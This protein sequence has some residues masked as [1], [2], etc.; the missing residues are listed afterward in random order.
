MLR[1]RSIKVPSPASSAGIRR[2]DL[3]VSCDGH[4][5]E[6]WIDFYF[7][8]SGLKIQLLFRRAGIQRSTV[9][10]RSPGNDW[11]I[12]FQGQE[13]RRCRRKCVFCFVDQL[14]EGVRPSL[15]VKDDDVRYSFISG[16]YTTL[17]EGDAEFAL[18]R[19]L[20]PIHISVHA[21]DPS[22]R[23][24]LLGTGREEP[25]MESLMKLSA[26]GIQMETQ[27][28]V[29]PGYNDGAVL[30]STMKDLFSINGVSSVG[31]VP[32]GLTAFRKGLTELRR[33][34]RDESACVIDLCGH[35][36]KT[37]AVNGRG[38]W[39]FPS[40]EFFIIAD[41]GIPGPGYYE[42]CTLRENGIGMLAELRELKGRK[43]KGEG[44]VLT[45]EL[46]APFLSQLFEGSGYGVASVRNDFLGSSVGAAG[47]IAG[48]DAVR[49]ALE[50][51]CSYNRMILPSV[52]FNHDMQTLDGLTSAGIGVPAGME[53]VIAES[54]EELE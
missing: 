15:K 4:E 8:G 11:G 12:T 45:G 30:E 28:V 44:L 1:I 13:P 35:W 27:I 37:A 51:R 48:R 47:L 19:R 7:H 16:T 38:G 42:G 43:W 41:R 46:A 22:V 40:D 2:S 6:D 50:H 33:P 49:T 21:T 53:V 23:G 54:L 20:S 14:P 18:S 3:L 25:V 31:L 39:A 9:L 36:R 26:G 5:L 24:R 32:V 10:R 52:M 29:V 17:H 34:D